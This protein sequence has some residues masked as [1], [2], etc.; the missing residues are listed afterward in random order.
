[1]DCLRFYE[2]RLEVLLTI[3]TIQQS[4]LPNKISWPADSLQR[5]DVG[6]LYD[7]SLSTILL[8]LIGSQVSRSQLKFLHLIIFIG[9]TLLK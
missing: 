1:M 5:F 4:F 3:W 8:L 7:L 2:L 9:F 6:L